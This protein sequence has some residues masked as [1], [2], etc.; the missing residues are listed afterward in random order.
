MKEK[1]IEKRIRELEKIIAHHQYLYHVKDSPEIE[2]SVYD[3]LLNELI[4]LENKYP[5]FKSKNSPSHRVGGKVI[6]KFEKVKHQFRQ[7]SFDNVF[8]FQELKD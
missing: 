6:E 4:D 3:S 8:D 1:E 7:W 5:E 2:D